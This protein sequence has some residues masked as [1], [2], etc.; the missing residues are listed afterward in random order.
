MLQRGKLVV[1]GHCPERL[2]MFGVSPARA[3]STYSNQEGNDMSTKKPRARVPAQKAA[4]PA[5]SPPHFSEGTRVIKKADGKCDTVQLN[6]SDKDA[7]KDYGGSKKA[8]FNITIFREVLG[9]LWVPDGSVDEDATTRMM[10]AAAAALSAFKPVDEIEGMIAAQAVALH[11][12]A[13]ECLRRANISEQPFEIAARLRKDA[14][15]TMRTMTEMLEALD[16]KR[17]KA[18]QIVR[19]E[20]VVV[21]EGGQAIVGNVAAGG[22]G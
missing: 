21:H 18:P 2:A 9:C 16:R 1:R 15:N 7:F 11:F 14:A 5:P 3:Y 19:V 20:R 12:T 10:Q 13:M 17:G 8:A 6:A 22:R 4:P